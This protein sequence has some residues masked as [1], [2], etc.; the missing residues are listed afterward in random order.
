MQRVDV[1]GG[2]KRATGHPRGYIEQGIEVVV[3]QVSFCRPA[4]HA[5]LELGSESFWEVIATLLT[6]TT[7]VHRCR[8]GH[9]RA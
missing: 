9:S 4:V 6:S 2:D 7:A 5:A 8:L 1:L 3:A